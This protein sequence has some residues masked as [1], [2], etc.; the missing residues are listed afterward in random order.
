MKYNSKINNFDLIRLFLATSIFFSHFAIL[1][2]NEAFSFIQKYYFAPEL[3]VDSFFVLSGFLIF[4]SYDRKPENGIFFKKRILRILPAYLT[5]VVLFALLLFIWSDK[6]IGEYFSYDWLKYLFYNVIFLNFLQP[7]LPGVF[8]NN[9]IP[10]VNGALWTLK[11]EVMFYVSVPIIFYLMSKIN[12]LVV[13]IGIYI[14]SIIYVDILEHLY[15]S[16]SDHL[17]F[18]LIHQLP[19]EL[20][21]FVMGGILYFYYDY[22]AKYSHRLLLLALLVFF[23]GRYFDIR[24]FYPAALSIMVVYF[25]TIIKY[26]GNWGRHGDFSYAIYLVHFPIIQIFVTLNLID[27]YPFVSLIS[28]IMLVM[29]ISYI[30][31]HYLEKPFLRKKSHYIQ[32]TK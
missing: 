3:R 2:Q 21:F 22:F 32:E 28:I 23:V 13:L 26:L 14:M 7:T 30:S 10:A 24:F 29:F 4:L 8:E 11:V 19:G 16:T 25:A 9:T 18:S 6:S 1:S 17:Y 5:T 15:T 20:S 31:W 27:K 12:R